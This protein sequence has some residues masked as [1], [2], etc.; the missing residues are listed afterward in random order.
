MPPPP[1]TPRPP[2]RTQRKANVN[3]QFSGPLTL[4]ALSTVTG[5]SQVLRYKRITG[6]LLKMQIKI[7]QVW[8]FP[9]VTQQVKDPTSIHEDAGLIPGLSVG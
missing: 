1:P 3:L 7:L 8:E 6:D 5:A 4:L 2:E 9:P